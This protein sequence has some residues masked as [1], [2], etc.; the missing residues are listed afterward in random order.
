M[1]SSVAQGQMVKKNSWNLLLHKAALVTLDKKI[2]R[3]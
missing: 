1:H 3:W 2:L